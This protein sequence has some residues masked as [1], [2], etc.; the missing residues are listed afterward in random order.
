M[1]AVLDTE[2]VVA[3]SEPA[4]IWVED[5]VGVVGVD[6]AKWEGA[7]PFG[8]LCGGVLEAVL[9]VFALGWG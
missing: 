6:G 8:Y 4:F 7:Q 2:C 5:W 9:R 3:L 1:M